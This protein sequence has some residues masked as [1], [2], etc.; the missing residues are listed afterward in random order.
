MIEKLTPQQEALLPVYRDRW[1][2]IGNS[3]EPIDLAATTK[4]ARYFYAMAK[5][6][7]ADKVPVIAKKRPMPQLM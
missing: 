4:A 3:T 7:G 1:L 5:I 2:A 6:E